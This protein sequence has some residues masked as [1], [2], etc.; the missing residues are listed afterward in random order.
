MS[1]WRG[2]DSWG[3]VLIAAKCVVIVGAVVLAIYCGRG[4]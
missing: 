1:I 4:V 3:I 2:N